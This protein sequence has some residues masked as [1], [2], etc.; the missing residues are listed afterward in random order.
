MVETKGKNWPPCHPI[1]Y[2][3]IQAE[4]LESEAIQMAETSYKLWLAYIVTLIFNLAAVIASAA[5]GGA[6]D[7]IIQILLAS[8]YLLIWPIFDFISR[9]LSLYRA[10]KYDN[11][12]SYRFFF[13]ITFLDILF[14]VFIGIGFLAGGGG[15][16]IAMIYNFQ[17]KLIV[18]GVFNAICVFLVLSLTMFHTIL[19][20]KVY[21]YLKSLHEDW[22]V[23]PG[24]GK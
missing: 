17:H 6:G 20:R 23:I 10:F 3:D 1:I 24:T 5:S 8:I 2:H 22:N 15:G 18:A 9:H 21:K 16:L 13:L 12:N 11:L 19:F 4:I 7:L 14:G